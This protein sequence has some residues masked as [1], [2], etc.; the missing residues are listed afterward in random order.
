MNIALDYDGTFT[1]A[2]RL[3]RA[4][5]EMSLACGHNVY[6]ITAR[7][8]TEPVPPAALPFGTMVWYTGRQAKAKF[9]QAEKL[10]I[11]VWIDDDPL[12]ILVDHD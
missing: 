5:I 2:P 11:D 4:F 3:W 10:D 6:V 7:H 8:E 1:E 9:A 12:H